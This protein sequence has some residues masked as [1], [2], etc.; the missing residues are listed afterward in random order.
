VSQ[1][2]FFELLNVSMMTELFDLYVVAHHFLL[3]KRFK[4]IDLAIVASLNE[5]DLSKGTLANNFQC[6]KVLGF[7]LCPQEPQV[8]D[9]GTAHAVLLAHF[10]V[11][12]NGRLFHEGFEFEGSVLVLVM[13]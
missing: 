13:L 12:G 7:L 5:F 9:F 6:G 4:R 10:S 3:D 2:V 1:L 8:F 11:I